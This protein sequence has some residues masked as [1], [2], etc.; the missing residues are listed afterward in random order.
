M[1]EAAVDKQVA[2]SSERFPQAEEHASMTVC[3]VDCTKESSSITIRDPYQALY[4]YCMQLF[5]LYM[6]ATGSIV[7]L[8]L[9]ASQACMSHMLC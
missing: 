6:Y 4:I 2:V 9:V 8:P 7:A 1:G 3:R 5:V